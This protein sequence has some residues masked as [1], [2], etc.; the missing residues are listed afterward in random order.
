MER[1]DADSQFW[2]RRLKEE[3]ERCD[4]EKED[5]HKQL[6]DQHLKRV[7][8]ERVCFQDEDPGAPYTTTTASSSVHH[9]DKEKKGKRKPDKEDENIKRPCCRLNVCVDQ[10]AAQQH[11]CPAITK[12][13]CP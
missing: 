9:Q 8:I 12:G 13:Y 3:K 11:C 6:W 5:A 2:D 10:A 7:A 4:M 1:E